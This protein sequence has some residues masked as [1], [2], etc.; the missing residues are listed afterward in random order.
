MKAVP[1]GTDGVISLPAVLDTTNVE[2]AD[3]GGFCFTPDGIRINISSSERED[4]ISQ[5]YAPEGVE[6]HG[7]E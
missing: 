7:A 2:M 4:L 1:W 6:I 5:G 3:M